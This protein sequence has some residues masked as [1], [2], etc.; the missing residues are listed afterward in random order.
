MMD[1]VIGLGGA[2]H[3][4][5]KEFSKLKL[6][7]Q[8]F[9][10]DNYEGKNGESIPN[11]TYLS[12][13]AYATPEEYESKFPNFQKIFK[14][15][16][17]NLLLITAGGGHLSL[18]SLAL[19]EQLKN[20]F[21]INVLYIKPESELLSQQDRLKEKVVF[22]VFQEYARSGIFECLYLVSNKSIDQCLGGIPLLSYN[23]KI[24]EVI[25]STFFSIQRMKEIKPVFEIFHNPPIAA[26]IATIGFIDVEKDQENLF[27][28][29]D[30]PTDT[31]YYFAYSEEN[32]KND[33][34]LFT[35]IKN[36]IR[37]KSLEEESRISYGIFATNY[38]TD[39]VYCLKY[40]SIIQEA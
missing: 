36:M 3:A 8:L 15:L 17:G 23:E 37:D 35:N 40:T 19:L 25:A 10:I 27:F 7:S 31:M 34:N 14:K 20:K 24:N 26:R 6:P 18:C 1:V 13:P 21:K 29:L 2:G 16:K 11:H 28:N 39:I 30:T 4:L 38:D 32:L 22:N 12:I 9:T 33:S 5:V